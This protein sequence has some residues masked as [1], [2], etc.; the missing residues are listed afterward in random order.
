MTAKDEKEKKKK[1]FP[2][3]RARGQALPHTPSRA[4]QPPPNTEHHPAAHPAAPSCAPAA[5]RPAAY[6]LPL[7]QHS[8]GPRFHRAQQRVLD[9]AQH[10]AVWPGPARHSPSEVG[11]SAGAPP[12]AARGTTARM[13][14]RATAV[15]HR[16][17][18]WGR[19]GGVYRRAGTGVRLGERKKLG[20]GN[21]G[22]WRRW[23]KCVM[24]SVYP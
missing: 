9:H 22:K 2:P 24:L 20:M 5:A 23:L 8:V 14:P 18:G 3:F 11:G 10:V 1:L 7:A 15:T 6:L 17:E 16:V 13:R 12:P 21:I 4:A 19:P